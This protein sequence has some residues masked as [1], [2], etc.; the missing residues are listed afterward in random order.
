M[1][2]RAFSRS[3]SP[4][5]GWGYNEVLYPVYTWDTFDEKWHGW[6][7]WWKW[8][9][10]SR[11][12]GEDWCWDFVVFEWHGYPKTSDDPQNIPPPEIVNSYAYQISEY[13]WTLNYQM[14]YWSA[15]QEQDGEFMAVD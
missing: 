12:A 11:R 5:G 6:V 7:K 10:Y 14:T 9:D 8:A 13:E 2:D 3:R 4:G 15:V 1:V